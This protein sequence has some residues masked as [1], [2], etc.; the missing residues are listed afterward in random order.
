MVSFHHLSLIAGAILILLAGSLQV[1][2]A[3]I[4]TKLPE[5]ITAEDYNEFD[6]AKAKIGQLLFYDPILS[7]NR[8]ISCG[9]CHH[10]DHG[11]SDGLPLGIGEGGNGLGPER[12]PGTGSDRIAKRIPRNSPALWN[13]GAKEIDILFHDGRLSIS[14]DYDNGFNTPAEEW[15]PPGLDG[16]LAAQALFPLTAQFE[17]A[18]N[19][20]EN[21]I[22][23]AAHDR[24]DYVWPI[25]A[26]RVRIIPEYGRMFVEAFNEISSP[27]QVTITQIAN[28][29]GAFVGLEWQS[30]DSAFDRY[31]E[32]DEDA[33]S[34]SQLSGM[35]LFFG[36]G[37][38]AECHSG[39]FMS[40]QHFHAL[41]LPHFGPG[42]TRR[43]DPYVRDVGRLGE[44]DSLEDAYR[45]RT[46]QLR[47]VALTGPYGH[48][49][50][51]QT[52]EDMIRHHLN[53]AEEFA[54]WQ[55]EEVKL[56]EVSWLARADF[57][58]FEDSR[59]RARLA[60]K[61]DIAPVSLDDNEVAD[62]V[63]FLNALTGEASTSGRLGRPE[64][65]PSG[66]KVD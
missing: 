25:V 58:A 5:P 59:E 47:N 48:N 63:T 52:L 50:A 20:K 4:S 34:K 26:K 16:I 12:N 35:N 38:C 64:S 62:L 45:F 14:D 21:Q 57:I 66:L 17:M 6:P 41:A 42:R 30:H 7:G 23:G 40:D 53:P 61:I 49:G 19:P 43:F 24:I 65:V 33:Q 9:T 60:S 37:G 22:A 11:S 51:Y 27:E 31:L 2:A 36:K 46:P 54:N 15:L 28:A 29:I 8:N 32:G 55:A 1:N 10:H 56:P 39:K 44:T 18:G 13:L 3:G